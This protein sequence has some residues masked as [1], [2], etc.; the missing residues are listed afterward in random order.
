MPIF[1]E[2]YIQ[3]MSKVFYFDR[4]DENCFFIFYLIAVLL[5]P[6]SFFLYSRFC[7]WFLFPVPFSCSFF[8]ILSPDISSFAFIPISSYLSLFYVF[9]DLFS[10]FIF[11]YLLCRV[12]FPCLSYI[13]YFS[14]FF[15]LNLFPLMLI[16]LFFFLF[17]T[18]RRF[19]VIIFLCRSFFFELFSSSFL[20]WRFYILNF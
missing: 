5:L 12:L 10:S 7:F 2:V 6:G 8:V 9:L 20:S 18:L 1:F 11:S 3:L 15:F 17:A 19:F 13:I 14:N 16:L 4:I